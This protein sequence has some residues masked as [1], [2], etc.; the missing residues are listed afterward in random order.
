MALDIEQ[1]GELVRY[2][3]A[4]RRIGEE[5]A[6][7]IRVLAG[8]VSNRTVLVERESASW[9]LKQALPKLRVPVDWYSDPA[10][11]HREAAALRWLERNAPEGSVP[12]FVFEDREHHVL[13]MEAVPATYENWKEKLLAGRV[14][15]GDVERFGRLLGI[16]H[17]R[18]AEQ[19]EELQ[20]AFGDRAFFESLRLEPYYLYTAAQVPQAAGFLLALVEETRAN[21]SVLVHGDYSPKNV[22]V[23]GEHL[24]L[25][26][27]EVAHLGEPA[28]DLGFSLAHL[29]SK[30]HHLPQARDLLLASVTVHWRAYVAEAGEA[31]AL[32]EKA[33]RHTLACLLARTRGRSQLE[34]MADVE[35]DRQAAAVVRLLPRP[36]PTLER[37]V[38]DFAAALT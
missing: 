25:L 19:L 11:I 8:G 26:D 3:R 30:A 35:K 1:P 36:P 23:R 2:L 24:V 28:F 15:R 27:H 18:S 29:L 17:R 10:R 32:E 21:A 31:A 4:T 13:C 5:E 22:L 9:I 20:P 37:L 7:R 6:P 14:E 16:V 34:Y 33:V 12:G 38:A